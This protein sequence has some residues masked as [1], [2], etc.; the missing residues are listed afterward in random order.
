MFWASQADYGAFVDEFLKMRT[1]ADLPRLVINTHCHFD[2]RGG[3]AGLAAR[4]AEIAASGRDREFTEAALD[5][6][7]DA[8]LAVE[9]KCTE[10][11][12]CAVTRWLA[13]GERIPLSAAEDDYLEVV[14]TPGHTPDSL[15][16][17]LSRERRL[18]VGD[19]V[20]R[21]CAI[22]V[23]N[24]HSSLSDYYASVR[25]LLAF[26]GEAGA[27]RGA[28]LEA[29]AERD[30]A[31]EADAK[32]DAALSCGHNS[33]DVPAQRS[34]EAISALLDAALSGA[35]VP[36]M[37]DAGVLCFGRDEFSFTVRRG[38]FEACR[39]GMTL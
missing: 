18:F 23:D 3:N 15:C 17:W 29:G 14:H 34:L 11:K 28:A 30:A 25:K 27:E 21:W 13:D 33:E 6:T 22:I 5:P 9:V 2:H 4:G 31:L 37:D 24:G 8:S 38:D 35:L 1:T 32:C 10:A 7:R 20:Y 16:L 36:I 12:P 26:L 39:R 19:T